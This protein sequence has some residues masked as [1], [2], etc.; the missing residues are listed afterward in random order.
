MSFYDRVSVLLISLHIPILKK[1]RKVI[2]ALSC[3]FILVYFYF[4]VC[5]VFLLFVKIQKFQSFLWEAT[6]ALVRFEVFFIDSLGLKVV[7]CG[8]RKSA[9]E[10]PRCGLTLLTS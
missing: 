4:F 1:S 2:N 8:C 9:F 7:A 5:F 6:L 10:F 3:F